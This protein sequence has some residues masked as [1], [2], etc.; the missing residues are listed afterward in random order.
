M[1]FGRNFVGKFFHDCGKQKVWPCRGF[2]VLFSSPGHCSFLPSESLLSFL[3]HKTGKRVCGQTQKSGNAPA[4]MRFPP[5]KRSN[6][7]T[8][9]CP[10]FG[11]INI[12]PSAK[13]P[14]FSN[15]DKVLLIFIF[16]AIAKGSFF[17]IEVIHTV[18][19]Q[20]IFQKKKI[21]PNPK[22]KS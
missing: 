7:Q 2:S 19:N 12:F 17:S 10:R 3:G 9:D 14:R 16:S 13:S 4:K 22:D 1:D 5:R 6:G 21:K 8:I 15:F 18:D 11:H 20:I